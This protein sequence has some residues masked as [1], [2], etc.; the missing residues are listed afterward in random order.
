MLIIVCVETLNCSLI[1]VVVTINLQSY[2]D[3]FVC[4]ITSLI[5]QMKR[6]RYDGIH[7]NRFAIFD[8]GLEL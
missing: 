5:I 7:G 3:L 2:N 6:N 1:R 8:M 4:L